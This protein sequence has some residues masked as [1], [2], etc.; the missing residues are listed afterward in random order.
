MTAVHHS[1]RL[2][3]ALDKTLRKAAEEQ[4]ITVYAMLQRCVK[5]GLAAPPEAAPTDGMDRESIAELA[6]VSTRLV[7][8][9]QLLDRLLFTACAAYCYARGAARGVRETDAVVTAQIHAAY[10]RQRRLAEEAGR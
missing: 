6:S 5:A 7:H 4:G 1:V 8:V 9:E 3:A 10:D 2:S